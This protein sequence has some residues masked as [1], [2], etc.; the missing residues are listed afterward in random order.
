M[1]KTAAAGNAL[2]V[3]AAAIRE[4]GEIGPAEIVAAPAA[5]VAP[6]PPEHLA[7]AWSTSTMAQQAPAATAAL[8]RVVVPLNQPGWSEALSQRVLLMAGQQQSSAELHLN[9]P[10]L[11]PVSITLSVENDLAN[12]FFSSP[13]VPVREA[14][15]NALP[16]LREAL[17]QAGIQLGETGVSA[18]SFRR[19]AG[20]AEQQ[21]RGGTGSP[22][23][24]Q[25]LPQGTPPA[26]TGGRSGLVDTF[27]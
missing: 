17:G 7:N 1:A 26:L 14:I 16:T 18:E 3:T 21:G 6:S 15:E 20:G 11:G 2:P 4:T 22:G 5:P 8:S 9:P 27:A 13:L 12:V 24:G 23:A 10:E 19:E 25:T